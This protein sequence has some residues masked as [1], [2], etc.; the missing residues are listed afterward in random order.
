MLVIFLA[1]ALLSLAQSEDY[2]ALASTWD[3]SQPTCLVPPQTV[4]SEEYLKHSVGS[5]ATRSDQLLR[6]PQGLI[7]LKGNVQLQYLENLIESEQISLDTELQQINLQDPFSVQTPTLSLQSTEGVVDLTNRTF[8]LRDVVF[9]DQN[10]R[11][12]AKSLVGS[13]SSAEINNFVLTTCG[14]TNP[15]WQLRISK[16][17]RNE[18]KQF[19]SIRHLRLKLGPVPILYLPYFRMSQREQSPT[20]VQAPEVTYHSRRGLDVGLPFR[21]VIGENL[22]V[23]L[24][25]GYLTKRGPQFEIRLFELESLFQF[26]WVPE[27][28]E[29]N[30]KVSRDTFFRTNPQGSFEPG[31]RWHLGWTRSHELGP[32]LLDIEIDETSDVD[33]WRDYRSIR[34]GGG[35]L[36]NQSKVK[37]GYAS[38]DWMAQLHAQQFTS[39]LI[40][41]ES[42][43]RLPELVLQWRPRFGDFFLET[44]L[45]YAEY[46][47]RSPIGFEDALI[48]PSE[49]RT[50]H[51]SRDHK[52]QFVTFKRRQGAAELEAKVGFSSTSFDFETDSL[53]LQNTRDQ[54][55][56]SLLG[57]LYMVHSQGDA[58]SKWRRTLEP[59]IYYL[60]RDFPTATQ[61][62]RFDT[63]RLRYTT[64]RLF[65]DRHYTGLDEIPGRKSVTIGT[66][67][68]SWNTES[69]NKV[70]SGGIGWIHHLQVPFDSIQSED[71]L[72]AEFQFRAGRFGVSLQQLFGDTELTPDETNLLLG[73]YGEDLSRVELTYADRNYAS[74]EQFS[75][76]LHKQLSSKW[77]VF[78]HSTYDIENSQSIDRFLGLSFD[79]CCLNV[80]F[81]LRESIDVGEISSNAPVTFDR[82]AS[83]LLTFKGLFSAG[84]DIN[85]LLAKKTLH[86]LF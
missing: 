26:S 51:L 40:P 10:Q 9:R 78:L 64:T 11:G 49:S 42:V 50:S 77:M 31:R 63:S 5:I 33:Y 85:N 53:N 62:P 27:D 60:H 37:L 61:I 45:N 73:Y 72:G 58:G 21:F 65:S 43:A 15:A 81:L 3:M 76:N 17:R 28:L 30:G 79:N 32:W 84:S 54:W 70:I 48:L 66:T 29:H 38:R 56:R 2:K 46:L 4:K 7:F 20:G 52:G 80:K 34:H 16:L 19:T 12:S 83:L 55:T 71:Q 68:E 35:I 18:E 13:E 75:V 25:P 41:N 59:K 8:D 69:L 6:N 23:S 82:G 57:T 39:T 67:F 1:T 36:A 74:I 24:V 22:P 47:R 44:H 86:D 14:S